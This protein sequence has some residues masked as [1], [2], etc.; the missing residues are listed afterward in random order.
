[1]GNG[2]AAISTSSAAA[3]G[4]TPLV[5]VVIPTYRSGEGLDRLI[6]SLDRQS[7]SAD[8]FEIIFVDDGS[9]DDTHE[10]LLRIQASRPNVVVDR[11]EN[12]GWPSRPRNVGLDRASGTY[13]AFMDHD[14]ELYPDALRAAVAM[15]ERTGADVVNGKEVRTN[16]PGWAL[17]TY[18][19]TV[20]NAVGMVAQHALLPMNPHKLYRRE[21]LLSNDIRFRE[22]RRVLWEDIFFNVDVARHAR[23]ISVMADTPYYHWV[24]T[25][26]SGSTSYLRNDTEWWHAL[27]DVLDHTSTQLDGIRDNLDRDQLLRHQYRSRLLGSFNTAF[28]R[29]TP[30]AKDM[31]FGFCE[32]LTRDYIPASI[33]E[34]LDSFSRVRAHLVRRGDRD[35]LDALAASDVPPRPTSRVTEAFWHDGSLSLT[36]TT[37]W[38]DRAG[39]P[40]TFTATEGRLYRQ[41]PAGLAST[42]DHDDLDVTREVSGATMQVTLRSERTLVTTLVPTRSTVQTTAVGGGQRV[43]VESVA[44]IDLT[45][46]VDD[47]T[48]DTWTI[49][50]LSTFGDTVR[51][52]ALNSDVRDAHAVIDGRVLSF[53]RRADGRL[54]MRFGAGPEAVIATTRP[55]SISAWCDRETRRTHTTVSLPEIYKDGDDITG[56]VIAL[57][58]LGRTTKRVVESWKLNHN[59]RLTPALR[60]LVRFSDVTISGHTGDTR[61]SFALPYGGRGRYLLALRSPDGS[62]TWTPWTVEYKNGAAELWEAR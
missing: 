60:R 27:R 14:D 44:T 47:E 13:V 50:S 32:S 8:E 2:D 30:E 35:T 34:S 52:T 20:D 46:M 9:P 12:S 21:F 28:Q 42:L 45:A 7:L 11:I 37:Q 19:R 24:V 39:A 29:R 22:G 10:R 56:T 57:V 23:V 53:A 3:T 62:I 17:G 36:V 59:L 26:K 33:D 5:S 6:R 16:D 25:G 18:Q 38:L 15:A 43:T 55:G 54:A 31:I 49:G 40:L 61:M 1:M 41:H 51:H 4:R 48:D 58:P